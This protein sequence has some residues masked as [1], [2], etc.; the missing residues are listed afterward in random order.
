M[1]DEDQEVDGPEAAMAEDAAVAVG[2]QA[3]VEQP[4][5]PQL[6]PADDDIIAAAED[7]VRQ[8]IIA[9]ADQCIAKLTEVLK[10]SPKAAARVLHLIRNV[11]ETQSQML[12]SLG[13][14]T[15]VRKRRRHGVYSMGQGIDIGSS[16]DF[17]M[18]QIGGGNEYSPGGET[19]GNQALKQVI[20]AF[21]PIAAAALTQRN[22]E[23]EQ[24]KLASVGKLTEAY[25]TA[26]EKRLPD[27]ITW[28]L[29]A[30]LKE[31]LKP[32]A[33][34]LAAPVSAEVV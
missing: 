15:K 7:D 28:A 30:K 16:D 9:H 8:T 26:R 32:A 12:V 34:G 31:L 22:A 6:D 1:Y 2:K 23:S 33:E 24:H 27:E 20:A 3:F 10:K 5:F 13:V 11:A 4:V 25:A 21:Q 29:E 19:F 14:G 17:E 18:G